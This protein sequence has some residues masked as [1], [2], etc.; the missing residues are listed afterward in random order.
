[1]FAH[2]LKCPILPDFTDSLK[3]REKGGEGLREGEEVRRRR[4]KSRDNE[5]EAK[6]EFSGGKQQDN[7][8]QRY[9]D[10]TALQ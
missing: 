9:I 7:D 3:V 8:S 4:I 10:I 6:N 1:M 2:T 5:R